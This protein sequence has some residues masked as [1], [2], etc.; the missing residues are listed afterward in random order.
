MTA[1]NDERRPYVAPPLPTWVALCR[2]KG[3]SVKSEIVHVA[4]RSGVRTETRHFCTSC[5]KDRP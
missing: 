2:A 5:G 3:H 1:A 4:D